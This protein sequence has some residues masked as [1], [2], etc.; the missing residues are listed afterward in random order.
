MNSVLDL[1]NGRHLIKILQKDT[2]L[3]PSTAA[4]SQLINQSTR[5][6][7]TSSSCIDL[8]FTTSLSFVKDLGVEL[9]LFGKCDHNIIFG[10]K[11]LKFSFFLLTQEK[12][13]AMEMQ[14]WKVYKEV[15]LVLTRTIFF[16]KLPFIRKFKS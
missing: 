13:G 4:Y 8:I 3:N 7:N 9:S 15:F 5:K 16:K 14:M 11:V 1:P 2:K 6:I 10:K 12:C